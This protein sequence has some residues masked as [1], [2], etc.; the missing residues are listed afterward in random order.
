MSHAKPVVAKARD[1]GVAHSLPRNHD[2]R[3]QIP[4]HHQKV[5]QLDLSLT[6]HL[7]APKLIDDILDLYDPNISRSDQ[8]SLL[9]LTSSV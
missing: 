1:F 8:N 3:A 7:R 5:D 6:I 9:K 2:G 4:G